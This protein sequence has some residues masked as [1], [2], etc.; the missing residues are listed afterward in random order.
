MTEKSMPR[1]VGRWISGWSSALFETCS[2]I[3]SP[4]LNFSA[5]PS[6]ACSRALDVLLDEHRR[7]SRDAC[8]GEQA[9]QIQ[10]LDQIQAR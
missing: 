5:A 2:M 8:G 9:P 6:A 3:T 1:I 10:R 7:L 4:A